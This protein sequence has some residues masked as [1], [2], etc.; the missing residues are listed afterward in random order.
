M[1]TKTARIS[2]YP[3]RN[4]DKA[5]FSADKFHDER[6]AGGNGRPVRHK[7]LDGL[8]NTYIF[9]G[10]ETA[11]KVA[12][13]IGDWSYNRASSWSEETHRTV[14]GIEYGGMN[15]ALY[16]LYK[17]TGKEEHLK[18]AHAFDEDE[19]FKKIASGDKNVLN[20]RH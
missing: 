10:Y 1:I 16:K 7:I 5:A 18:A 13:G 3:G 8:V 9:T 19:L 20:N 14:L 17:L 11:L 15:D 2:K 12:E 4:A 6:L